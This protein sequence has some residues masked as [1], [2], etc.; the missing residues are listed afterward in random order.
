[1]DLRPWM[2]ECTS[3]LAA[4]RPGQ[5]VRIGAQRNSPTAR[6]ESP[7]TESGTEP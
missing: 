1:V 3:A 7:A 2:A 5:L 6:P 4:I